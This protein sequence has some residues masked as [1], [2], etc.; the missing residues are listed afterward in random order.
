LENII[1]CKSKLIYFG[2]NC[3]N[4]CI[5]DVNDVCPLSRV[6]ILLVKKYE[7]YFLIKNKWGKPTM[8]MF[9]IG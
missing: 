8:D 3:E 1:F 2:Y 6:K 4:N 7:K 5:Y 9:L